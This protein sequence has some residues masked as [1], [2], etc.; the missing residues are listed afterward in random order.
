MQNFLDT[1]WNQSIQRRCVDNVQ[2]SEMEME[3]NQLKWLV[4]ITEILLFSYYE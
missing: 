3:M 4:G 1:S 2:I